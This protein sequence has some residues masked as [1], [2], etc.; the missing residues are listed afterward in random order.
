FAA[1]EEVNF[2]ALGGDPLFLITG[3]TGSGK[4]TL[5]DAMCFGLYG[6][7]WGGSRSGEQLRSDYAGPDRLT[8]VVFEF[9]LGAERYRV[10]RTPRQ[11]RSSQRKKGAVTVA[12]P[13]AELFRLGDP[14]EL[15]ASGVKGVDAAMLRIL[16]FAVEDFRQVVMLPQGRF[17]EL[18]SASSQERQKV[19]A[20]IFDT[21]RFRDLVERLK[22]AH[23]ALKSEAEK[24]HERIASLL[25]TA[26]SE[27]VEHLE[28]RIQNG[29]AICTKMEA[30]VEAKSREVERAEKDLQAA[31]QTQDKFDAVD[32]AERKV[33]SLQDGEALLAALRQQLDR[34][35]TADQLAPITEQVSIA[36]LQARTAEEER[37]MALRAKNVAQAD[38]ESATKA[39]QSAQEKRQ[40]VPGLLEES[41]RLKALGERLEVLRNL[42]AEVKSLASASA[43]AEAKHQVQEAESKRLR[44]H[45]A[46]LEER[47][48]IL[49]S[50]DV[51]RRM[52]EKQREDLRRASERV[53]LDVQ[54][55]A[56]QRV[57]EEQKAQA[58]ERKQ[59]LQDL[60]RREEQAA[61]AYLSDLSGGLAADL[62]PDTP[63]PVCGSTTHPNPATPS[64]STPSMALLEEI[65][66]DILAC[67]RALEAARLSVNEKAQSLEGV[68]GKRSALPAFE[69]SLDAL[70]E[71]LDRL[72]SEVGTLEDPASVES[73]E[74]AIED[75]REKLAQAES[76]S[77][78]AFGEARAVQQAYAGTKKSLEEAE[79]AL[80]DGLSSA[81]HVQARQAQIEDL[82]VRIEAESK[83]A[84][85]QH[86]ERLV[87][88]TEAAK[89]FELAIAAAEKAKAA[90]AEL[91]EKLQDQREGLGFATE[92]EWK[93]SLRTGAEQDVLEGRIQ[94]AT[95][96]KKAAAMALA[97]AKKQVEG[98][99]P[100]TELAAKAEKLGTLRDARDTSIRRQ[101]EYAKVLE[102]LRGLRK[103]VAGWQEKNREVEE[104]YAVAAQLAETAKGK[105]GMRL[106][107][108]RYVLG[109]MLDDVLQTAGQRLQLMSRGRY[110]LHR[111]MDVVDGRRMGGLDLEVM[112]HWTGV[113]RPVS[114]LSGGEGFL[115]ALSLA[116]GLADVI[117][118]YSG[119]IR[120]DA[121]FVDE[122]FGS[123]DPEALEQ[124]MRALEDLRAAGRMVGIIS[125]VSELKVRIDTRLELIQTRRGSRIRTVS[126]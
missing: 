43:E 107:F 39:Q 30:D 66:A 93:D 28:E 116:L 57:L 65:R 40:Q 108:E 14:E 34:A 95:T 58:S 118:A 71:D 10:E 102:Q 126:S 74:L 123:L 82:L 88:H 31:Q 85:V 112:D 32:Q 69:G 15:L 54:L 96:E 81:G 55:E 4:S 25:E 77:T 110:T 73:L 6:K 63:C 101:G 61:A 79:A 67:K 5:L 103:Q 122:G 29:E 53:R 19:L 18:L 117:Q 86:G 62:E 100:V 26:E 49:R 99:E 44:N 17:R 125:H 98:L 70:Q 33:R 89:G 23:T 119:G 16:G 84:N 106:D 120:L 59:S 91:R 3:A 92:S 75:A 52:L 8:R 68:R 13:T 22:K 11:E 94:Q 105:N 60:E 76:L 83:A 47:L 41:H 113:A 27:S 104:R 7:S 2:E 12:Q 21:A 42:E 64:Q 48:K 38:F 121:V 87:A 97:D 46:D 114:T 24:G 50:Q 109:V 115:A 45:I 80:P 9:A 51:K 90:H 56:G 111:A 78:A 36:G 20:R 124:A 72:E 35:K 1:E 37:L